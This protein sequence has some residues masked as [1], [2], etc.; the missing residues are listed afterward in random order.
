MEVRHPP[1]DPETEAVTVATTR[2]RSVLRGWRGEAG[3]TALGHCRPI[4]DDSASGSA[5][6]RARSATTA[7]WPP[8]RLW[9]IALKTRFPSAC[10]RNVSSPS[11]SAAPR[12]RRV[13][14]RRRVAGRSGVTADAPLDEATGIERHADEMR[15]AC[16][17]PRRDAQVVHQRRR[18]SSLRRSPRR[19]LLGPSPR[20]RR[21]RRAG[22][23]G[24]P[25]R[26]SAASS[27]RG[28]CWRETPAASARAVPARRHALALRARRCR[29]RRR[30][31]QSRRRP[32]ISNPVAVPM[33][34]RRAHTRGELAD[35]RDD[36]TEGQE[37]RSD[38]R[39]QRHCPGAEQHQ[40]PRGERS[41]ADREDVRARASPP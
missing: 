10:S 38:E 12:A 37:Q 3:N 7:T 32:A 22:S 2:P 40:R 29:R 4:V 8:A 28:S 27:R 35:A 39:E 16:L 11:K 20:P 14:S 34:R 41:G 9:R 5:R 24:A 33:H 19:P 26:T 31:P 13:P 17:E 6:R 1:R 36:R 23:R 21:S 15:L 18:C 25:A 30:A